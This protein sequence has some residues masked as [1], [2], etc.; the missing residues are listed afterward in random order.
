MLRQDLISTITKA[1]NQM[2]LAGFEGLIMLRHNLI[3]AI[4][5]AIENI[6]R[7]NMARNKRKCRGGADG[8]NFSMKKA[9]TAA[10]ASDKAETFGLSFSDRRIEG[11][12]SNGNIYIQL[13]FCNRIPSRNNFGTSLLYLKLYYNKYSTTTRDNY[14]IFYFWDFLKS[15]AKI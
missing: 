2:D 3:G 6:G 9:K 7:P 14:N 4:T 1:I 10:R 13:H 15:N 12:V 11:E 8:S 5:E